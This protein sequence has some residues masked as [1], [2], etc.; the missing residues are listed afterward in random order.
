MIKIEIPGYK[1]LQLEHLVLD[2]NGTLACDGDLLPGVRLCLESL[3]QQVHI[4]VL[5]A[6]T[7]GK[8]RA[9]LAGLPCEL[10][11]FGAERQD[12]GKVSYV[13]KLGAIHVAAIGNG[14]NDRLML[15]AAA[16]AIAVIQKED[17]S[18]GTMADVDV[19]TTDIVHALELLQHP[20][21]LI[22][23]LRS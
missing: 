17:A 10:T 3:S 16:L 15:K 21:R 18:V 20:L 22:A 1:I 13:E 19:V 12:L 23:T 5:T 2:F 9:A 6:D 8:A 11:V 7:F 4:H 14:R